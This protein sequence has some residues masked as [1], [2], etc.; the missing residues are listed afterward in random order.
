MASNRERLERLGSAILSASRNELYFSMRF[1]DI[2]LSGLDYRMNLNTVTVGTDGISILFNPT[3]L[4][5]VYR[6]DLVELNRVY[7]HM[8]LHCMFRHELNREGRD[9]DLWTVACDIAVESILDGIENRSIQLSVSTFREE[10]YDWLSEECPVLTAEAIYRALERRQ[11]QYLDIL[12]LK[13]EFLRDDHQFW[14]DDDPGQDE[15]QQQEESDSPD[16]RAQQERRRE[17]E[18]KWKRID[19]KTQTNLETFFAGHGDEMGGLLKSIQIENRERY[20]YRAFLR[21]FVTLREE[22]KTD[23]DSFDYAF[24]SYG[25]ELYGNIPLIEPLEYRESRKI[26]DFV[27]VIDTSDSCSDGIIERFLSET[28]AILNQESAFFREMNLHI[29]QSDA[30]VQMDTVLHSPEEF[31]R[32]SRNFIVKGYGGTD[33]RPAFDYVANL[34]AQGQLTELKG[35][36][37]FTDGFGTY[38]KKK[39]PYDTACVFFREEYTDAQVPP[40][41]MKVVLGPE[42]L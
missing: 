37:Y 18:A 11:V 21:R 22:V 20:D 17:V 3:Y 38:P 26:R 30:G 31:D 2:A 16:S 14:Q 40:W 19:E 34:Q 9:E 13:Q 35:L 15:S 42:E 24:Y 10:T 25:L 7:L 39:P 8:I 4:Q 28:R 27:I 23:P 32:F 36:L 6:D 1:L 5:R 29:I 41:A 33:F 12:R